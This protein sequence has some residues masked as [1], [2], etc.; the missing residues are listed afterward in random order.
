MCDIQ[1]KVGP[2]TAWSG[3]YHNKINVAATPAF[4]YTEVSP[5]L[6]SDQDCPM[7]EAK[8]VM[9]HTTTIAIFTQGTRCQIVSNAQWSKYN[10]EK[11]DGMG[12]NIRSVLYAETCLN[13]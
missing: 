9:M 8:C 4:L 1:N 3:Q 7:Q 5:F 11:H 6:K 12:C 2:F 10:E 13:I